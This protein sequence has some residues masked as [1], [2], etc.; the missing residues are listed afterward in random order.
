MQEKKMP[1]IRKNFIYRLLYEILL[2]AIPLVTMPYVSRVLGADGVGT[3]S[4]TYSVISYF[5]VFALLGTSSYGTREIARNRDNR[6]AVSQLFWQIEGMSILTGMV[7]I[8]AWAVLIVFSTEHRIF[9]LTLT[10]FLLGSMFDIVWFYT[11][12]EQ[13]GAMV[14]SSC[15]IRIAGVILVFRLIRSKEDLVLYFLIN[16]FVFLGA[17]MATWIFLPKYL[18]RVKWDGLHLKTHFRQSL[19]FF[20]PTIASSIY[21]VMDKTLIGLITG[22]SYQNG[23]YEQASKWIAVAQG[24]SFLVF[25]TVSSARF[26]YLF[27]EGKT[28]EIRTGIRKSF[29]FVFL[30]SYGCAFGLLGIAHNLV[31]VFFG[32]G[33]APV[34]TLIY[35]MLP[36]I[37]VIAISNCLGRQYYTPAGKRFQSAMYLVAGAVLNLVLNL[38]LIPHWGAEGAVA[39]S[40]LAEMLISAL[41]LLYCEKMMTLKQIGA[42]SLKRVIAGTVMAAC[43]YLLGRLMPNTVLGLCLQIVCG[44]ILYLLLLLALKDGFILETIAKYIK[45]QK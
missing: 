19:I 20:I 30:M 45:R 14:L 41:Y 1:D 22:N 42:F 21:L 17:N 35:L 40:L 29:D 15:L 3:Y 2:F 25:N 4:Y 11:G 5:I 38:L 32:E 10:P 24:C 26:S 18:T 34:E 37:P 44:A 12:L 39:A 36:L 31:P 23:Y 9:F 16:A 13:I 7:S 8:L 33:F 28:E 43:V 27:G 6:Q